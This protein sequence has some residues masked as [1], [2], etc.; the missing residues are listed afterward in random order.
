MS[1]LSVVL[2]VAGGLATVREQRVLNRERIRDELC[3]KYCRCT[4]APECDLSPLGKDVSELFCQNSA[5]RRS[6]S[7]RSISMP[8]RLRYLDVDDASHLSS[9]GVCFR[10]CLMSPWLEKDPICIQWFV[11]IITVIIPN[12]TTHR[13]P[14]Q[15]NV[16]VLGE[17]IYNRVAP[18]GCKIWIKKQRK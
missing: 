10:G 18:S 16:M 14:E 15:N 1:V 12:D 6:C 5:L 2:N 9:P 3:K 7:W 17:N 8:S 11:N 4:I 13:K